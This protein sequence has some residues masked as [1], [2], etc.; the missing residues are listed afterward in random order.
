MNG[1]DSNV[2]DTDILLYSSPHTPERLNDAA[3]IGIDRFRIIRSARS[4]SVEV[5]S[6]EEEEDEEHTIRIR[7]IMERTMEEVEDEDEDYEED[8]DE[9]EKE[10]DQDTDDRR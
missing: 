8:D 2:A 9:R 6:I 3:G 1:T 10:I 4:E 7:D 5:K